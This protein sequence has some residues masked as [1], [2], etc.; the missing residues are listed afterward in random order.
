MTPIQKVQ[1]AIDA[2][3]QVMLDDEA[4]ALMDDE[5]KSTV[6]RGIGTLVQVRADLE[7][8]AAV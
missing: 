7:E 3:V 1:A 8:T 5:D 6:L 4:V 2:T